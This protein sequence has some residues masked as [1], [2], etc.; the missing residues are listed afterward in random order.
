MHQKKKALKDNQKYR[1]TAQLQKDFLRLFRKWFP[2]LIDKI[3]FREPFSPHGSFCFAVSSGNSDFGDIRFY[4][5]AD[6]I[7]V[8]TAFDHCHIGTYGSSGLS[9]DQKRQG[10]VYSALVTVKEIISGDIIIVVEKRGDKI[11]KSYRYHKDDPDDIM[12]AIIYP[13]DKHSDSTVPTVRVTV[14]WNGIIKEEKLLVP[15]SDI[16]K[17]A[18]SQTSNENP[19]EDE[20]AWNMKKLMKKLS[21]AFSFH[22]FE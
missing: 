3:E 10:A 14:N 20:A 7:T 13:K 8:Y 1:P 15:T 17:R 11:L 18:D 16:N 12:S 6:E 19:S 22:F 9:A 4:I 5:C 21:E 2:N